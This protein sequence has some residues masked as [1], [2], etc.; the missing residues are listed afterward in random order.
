MNKDRLIKILKYSVILIAILIIVVILVN[1]YVCLS[2]KDLIYDKESYNDL[3]NIDAIVVLGAGIRNNK[4]SPLLKDRLDK[5][6][7]LYNLGLSPKIIMSGDHGRKKYDEVSVM[8]NYAIEN[9]VPSEDIFMDHAGF[10]TYES[11]YRARDIFKVKKIVIVT[12]KYHIYRSL[13][14]AKKLGVT[15]YGIPAEKVKYNGRIYREIREVLA[16]NKDV[17]QCIFK[18]K[19]TYLGEEI[20]LDQS[21]DITND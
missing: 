16:R 20:S 7:E 13:Y 10:S 17:L 2:V 5:A 4:P 15:A 18:P 14:I 6:I 11:I 19:P 12:Q 8:K 21:G 3:D 9:G 1:A